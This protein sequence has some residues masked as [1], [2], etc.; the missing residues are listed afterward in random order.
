M[1]QE[2]FSEEIQP[3]SAEA[4][5]RVDALYRLYDRF[6]RGTR[7]DRDRVRRCRAIH[8]LRDPQTR[9]D[10][11]QLPVLLSTVQN[12]IADQNDN[13]PEA[14]L[15]PESPAMQQYAEDATDMV[16][17]VFERNDIGLLWQRL[18]EDFFVTGCAIMQIHWD[19]RLD[20]GD[21]GIRVMRVPV[22]SL[23]WDPA[24]REMGDC[25][26]VF[27][28]AWKPLEWYRDRFPEAGRYV[29]ADAY[30][31]E[32]PFSG[33][34]DDREVMLLEAW[35]REY[36]PASRRYAVHMSLLAGHALLYDSRADYPKGLFAHGEY[37]FAMCTYRDTVGSMVGRGVVDDFVELNRYASRNARY[38]DQATRYAACPKLLL[39][40]GLELRDESELS[41]ADKQIIHMDGMLTGGNLLWMPVPQVPPMAYQMHRTYIDMLKQE[42]GQNQ[43]ARGEGGLGVT[44][45]S[46]I[47]SLQEA[48][49]KSSRM[50]AMRLSSMY[51]A[52]AEQVLWLIA[53]FFDP[54][55]IA[56]IN[57]REGEYVLRAVA[58]GRQQITQSADLHPAYRVN[59]Q[60]KKRSPL[61][62]E[63]E[64]QLVLQLF[65]MSQRSAT[66]LS[67]T[68]ALE[69]MQVDGKQRILD[70]LYALGG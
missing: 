69:L 26:A 29:R 39:G 12:K 62:V 4:R 57:G 15:A 68:D 35:Q 70:R 18:C 60:V 51:C 7:A 20:G 54:P 47:Q 16:R 55:R 56:M 34:E 67:V 44:A 59:I 3:L 17:W 13:T 19:E 5:R 27:R 61:R 65:E 45:A 50:E 40:Q 53:Q 10:E 24:A 48:G 11:P 8:E 52:A 66:P 36:D 46:A 21:G 38:V 6:E 1:D 37:P 58:L 31:G 63:S 41:R 30:S 9:A 64:N 42:S 23:V 2:F 14:V 43:F 25:R 49:A 32:T 22:E 33:D 28:T